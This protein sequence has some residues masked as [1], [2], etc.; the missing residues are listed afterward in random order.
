MLARL[1][2]AT[3]LAL[4][5]C[6]ESSP[7]SSSPSSSPHPAA[8]APAESAPGWAGRY[9]AA[10]ASPGKAG[11]VTPVVEYDVAVKGAG[12]RFDVTVAAD[13]FQTSKRMTG[14]G[15]PSVDG[16]E[17]TVR[18]VACGADDM[19]QCRG[20]AKGD[21]LFSL[22][23]EGQGIWLR[24]GKL[25]APDEATPQIKAERQPG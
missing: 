12:A 22:R 20:Y 5:A 16:R 11:G 15:A 24:F 1:L 4:P 21:A 18:F 19:F 3:L 23:R 10:W 14:E 8:G 17:L 9:K 25:T 6:C 2:F 13:G 7:G